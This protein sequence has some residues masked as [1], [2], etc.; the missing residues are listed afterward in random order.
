MDHLAAVADIYDPDVIGITETWMND[1]IDSA[2]VSL[3]GYTLFRQDRPNGRK[4]GGVCLYI[5]TELRAAE[6]Q[7]NTAFPEQIWCTIEDMQRTVYYI[8]VIYRTNNADIYGS[9]VSNSLCDLINEMHNKNIVLMGDFNYPEV[10]WDT[11][12]SKANA[13]TDTQTFLDCIENNCLIQHIKKPTRGNNILDLVITK[14]PDII[15][16][17][18]ILDNLAD[19]D[20]NMISWAVDIT[21]KDVKQWRTFNYNKG[22]YDDIRHEL[23]KVKWIE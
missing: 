20:H 23:Q 14:D 13:T 17:I 2:E 6:F 11:P 21:R 15:H 9:H 19:S 12:V 3:T 22:R 8:G 16:D 18:Q 10:D 4:G 1:Q 7:P 5:K